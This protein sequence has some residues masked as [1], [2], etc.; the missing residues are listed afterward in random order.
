MS[1]LK[2]LKNIYEIINLT[3][4]IAK[5]TKTNLKTTNVTTTK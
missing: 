5:T 3:T 4:K 2:K 1:F